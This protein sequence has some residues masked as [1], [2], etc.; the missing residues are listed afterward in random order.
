M[1][2]IKCNAGKNLASSVNENSREKS[3]FDDKN[4]LK[5]IFI[6][7][8]SITFKCGLNTKPLCFH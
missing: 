2:E 1:L 5:S 3:G 6:R 4:S 7:P 8:R